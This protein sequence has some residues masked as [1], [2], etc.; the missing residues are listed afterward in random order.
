M[1]ATRIVLPIVLLLGFAACNSAA[2]RE[3]QMK[4]LLSDANML[5]K[6]DTE[7]TKQWANEFVKTFTMENRSKFPANRDFLRTYAEKIIKLLDESSRF[8]NTAADKYE[9]AT[10]FTRTE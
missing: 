4:A 7:V 5:I 8:N 1:P 3:Q 10:K 6:Q 9:Q 2:R